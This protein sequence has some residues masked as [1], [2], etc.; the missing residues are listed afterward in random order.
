MGFRDTQA[1]RAGYRLSRARD[2]FYSDCTA[3]I[4]ARV[5]IRLRGGLR[6]VLFEFYVRGLI[7]L[8]VACLRV[9]L[10]RENLSSM[11][12]VGARQAVKSL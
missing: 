10:H 8:K 2:R 6:L 5:S 11:P 9:L 4:D 3:P 1:N 7:A 12:R